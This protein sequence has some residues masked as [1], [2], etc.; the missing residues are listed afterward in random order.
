MTS[1]TPSAQRHSPNQTRRDFQSLSFESSAAWENGKRVPTRVGNAIHSTVYS[2]RSAV[3]RP[4][5][6]WLW[7]N[8]TL[9]I[10]CAHISPPQVPL[11]ATSASCCCCDS[12]CCHELHFLS[13]EIWWHHKVNAFPVAAFSICL[14]Q[15]SSLKTYLL[16]LFF[17]LVG[18]YRFIT[19]RWPNVRQYL[20]WLMK[21][22][23]RAT[24][25]HRLRR[26]ALKW[27]QKKREPLADNIF[28]MEIVLRNVGKF[29]IK[30]TVQARRAHTAIEWEIKDTKIPGMHTWPGV[31]LGQVF[32]FKLE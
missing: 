22:Q 19:P 1:T 23:R 5:W 25:K 3:N 15:S 14:A 26:T 12:C 10:V 28:V 4:H 29:S 17:L 7:T 8:L 6:I 24:D 31:R 9:H 27:T 20:L 16:L 21:A 18:L 13:S 30:W 2:L 32:A 11:P